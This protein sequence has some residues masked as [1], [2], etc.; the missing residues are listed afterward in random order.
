MIG[1]S[2]MRE[3]YR[4]MG[5]GSGSTDLGGPSITIY[6]GKGDITSEEYNSALLSFFARLNYDYKDRYLVSASIRSDKSSKFA[7]GNRVGYFPSVSIGWNIHEEEFFNIDW[8]S[9][10]KIRASYGELGA[11]FID[12]YS[13]L[14]TAYG[15]IPSVFGENQT[16]QESVMNGYVTKFAQENLTWEKSISKNIALEMAFLNNQLS[17]TAEYF[18]KD[19]ND[20]LA[21]LLPLASSGQ[22]IMTNGGDLPVFNS[23]SVENKGFE[24]TVGYRKDWK[25]WSLGV[26]ANISALKNNVKSLGEGVQPIKAEVMMSGSFNDRPTITKPGLPIGTFWGYVIDGFDADGNFIFQDNNGSVDGVLTGKPDGKIDENDKTA[27]GNPHPDFTYGLN[28]NVGYKNWDL[29]AFFQGTQ[30]NDV[31]ALMKYDW[32]FGGANS[33]ILKDAF[34]NSW[35]P[36][37]TNAEAPK[38][39]SKNSSGINSLPSTFYVED[40]SYFR[41]KNL[42]IG[43]S[44]DRKLL[45]KFHVDLVR[46]YAG[47]Q[48]LFTITKYP[49]YDPEVSSNALFDRGVDGF[50]QAQESPHEATMNS[51]VYNIGINLTF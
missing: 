22:T 43:Y 15:P 11:N 42:Q 13:F 39:N 44:F 49:L 30:G 31:F 3:Y 50:W 38:L 51:R 25:D 36:Q 9:R 29:T 19:N 17:F 47:V 20:L 18:W 35:T 28:I 7:K 10:M 32:Y 40:G 37:N 46:I 26:T 33:A 23:A 1:T 2:W 45:Q 21:P 34:Y 12:P 41:C 27:I 4:T 48:N 24:F 16:G 5:I 14:S 8:I 6:N